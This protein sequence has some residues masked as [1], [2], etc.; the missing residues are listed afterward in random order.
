MIIRPCTFP[1]GELCHHILD[2][3]FLPW[4]I[5]NLMISIIG[6]SRPVISAT[7]HI[8][9]LNSSSSMVQGHDG[10]AITTTVAIPTSCTTQTLVQH[11][12]SCTKLAV[13]IS[14]FG[15]SPR[16]F[17][18]GKTPDHSAKIW[19]YLACSLDMSSQMITSRL[20]DISYLP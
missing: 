13:A 9:L 1:G 16:F 8:I 15:E 12:C 4:C 18:R 14:S 11:S 6:G 5:V 7:A 3:I 20:L 2:L 10:I 19:I 17:A